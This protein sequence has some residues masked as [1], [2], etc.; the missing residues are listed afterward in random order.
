MSTFYEIPAVP[1]SPGEIAIIGGGVNRGPQL[2]PIYWTQFAIALIFVAL[3][4]RARFLYPRHR[5]G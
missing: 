2:L 3:R 1:P 4:F 5:L